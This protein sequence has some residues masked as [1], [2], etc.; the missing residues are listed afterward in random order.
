[1]GKNIMLECVWKYTNGKYGIK[2]V[3]GYG[4][5]CGRDWNNDWEYQIGWYGMNDKFIC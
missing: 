3:I 1:M 5:E 4:L 2:V